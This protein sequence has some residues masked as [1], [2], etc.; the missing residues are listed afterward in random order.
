MSV[1]GETGAGRSNYYSKPNLMELAAMLFFLSM[2]LNFLECLSV[3]TT[4]NNQIN[5]C[6]RRFITSPILITCHQL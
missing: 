3:F 1:V 6:L 2:G 5:P 4:L